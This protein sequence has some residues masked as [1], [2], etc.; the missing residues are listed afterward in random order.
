MVKKI[1]ADDTD[2][3]N[4]LIHMIDNADWDQMWKLEQRLGKMKNRS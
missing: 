4:L 2:Y 3:L 1:Q